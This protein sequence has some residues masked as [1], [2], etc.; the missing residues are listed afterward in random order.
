MITE[1]SGATYTALSYSASQF[2]YVRNYALYTNIYGTPWEISYYTKDAYGWSSDPTE[3][4][5][6]ALV[7]YL[8]IT[9]AVLVVT[10]LFLSDE[11]LD[12]KAL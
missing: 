9:L 1:P 5:Q 3:A 10:A 4:T 11:I 6:A 8:G 2:L 12:L 7:G